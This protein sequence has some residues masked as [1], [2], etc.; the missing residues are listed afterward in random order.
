MMSFPQSITNADGTQSEAVWVEPHQRENGTFTSLVTYRRRCR[1][2]GA[3][4]TQTVPVRSPSVTL[5]TC[6]EHRG[7]VS[8]HNA[9]GSE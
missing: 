8:K 5:V 1:T 9:K 7:K 6:Q 4:F 3:E 2:C